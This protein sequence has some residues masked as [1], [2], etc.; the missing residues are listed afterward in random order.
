MRFRRNLRAN[1]TEAEHRLWSHPRDRHL[2]GFKFVRQE[3]VGPHVAD[4]VCREA[5]LIVE[6]DGSRHAEDTR[7][8]AG[9]AWPAARGFRVLRFWNTDIMQQTECV[10]AT[11][12]AALP[13]SPRLRG[14]AVGPLAGFGVS[15][16]GEGEGAFAIE[17]QFP[18]PPH[19]RSARLAPDEGDEALSPQ[20]ERG[21]ARS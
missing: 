1:E 10:T 17:S 9:D 15:P 4:F 7:D 12:L 8:Q 13:A 20:A 5:R 2:A 21:E 14:E 3:Q 6:A 18:V 19:P 11:I 16:Q